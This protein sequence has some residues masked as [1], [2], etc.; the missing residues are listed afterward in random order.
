QGAPALK[1]LSRYLYRGVLP[2]KAIVKVTAEAV[3]FRYQ[4]SATKQSKI[5]TLPTLKFLMLILQH[6]L[7]KG[8]RRVRD[9]GLLQGCNHHII[10]QVQLL[11]RV[12]IPTA[13]ETSRPCCYRACP[14]CHEPMLFKGILMKKV[15]NL[16]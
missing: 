9:Y 4:D 13:I 12:S 1:Y 3:S 5:R 11:L 10:Q 7:P 16:A 8:L 2:D 6:I 15:L 14:C